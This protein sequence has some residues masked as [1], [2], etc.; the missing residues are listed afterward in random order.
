MTSPKI[1][2]RIYVKVQY[3]SRTGMNTNSGKKRK[4]QQGKHLRSDLGFLTSNFNHCSTHDAI[5]HGILSHIH[6]RQ[7]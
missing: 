1:P 5:L 4:S 6:D 3:R 2:S 7:P